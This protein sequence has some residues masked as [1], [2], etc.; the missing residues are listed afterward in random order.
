MTTISFHT[1]HDG[2]DERIGSI[3]LD[4]AGQLT[5]EPAGIHLLERAIL[6]LREYGPDIAG[7]MKSLPAQ[8][9][10]AHLRAKLESGSPT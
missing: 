5:C 6:A 1:I 3:T 9:K 7:T 8:Y 4:D 2:D 10:S